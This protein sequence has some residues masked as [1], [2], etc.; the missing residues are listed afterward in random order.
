MAAGMWQ[1]LL[2]GY[3]DVEEK[4]AAREAKEEELM[5]K[6]KALALKIAALRGNNSFSV[7][8]TGTTSGGS[9]GGGS[10]GGSIEHSAQVLKSQFNL[11]DETITRV[12]GTA[13]AAG[14]NQALEILERTRKRYSDLGQEMPKDVVTNLFDSAVLTG[15]PED[16]LDFGKLEEYIGGALD[17]LERELLTVS[18]ASTGQA[19]FPEPSVLAPPPLGDVELL[20]KRGLNAI[21]QRATIEIR[22]LNN[23]LNNIQRTEESETDPTKIRE[24]S[25]TKNWIIERQ[26]KVKDALDSGSGDGGNPFGLVNLYGNE[27]LQQMFEADPRFSGVVLSPVFQEATSA[28]PKRVDSLPQLRNLARLGVIRVGDTVEILDPS[29]GEYVL[30]T[31]GE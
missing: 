12:A 8:T 29:T 26:A 20:E 21:T 30:Q 24:L 15:A 9:T 18:R 25:E 28:A 23:A 10:T 1:G 19:Y 13:G 11:S 3:K 4:I 27:F 22:S 5:E 2:A 16:D 14:L 31:I 7:G 6:R 17:P